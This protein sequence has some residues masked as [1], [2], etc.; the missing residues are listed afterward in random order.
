MK[1]H[2]LTMSVAV[3]SAALVWGCQE[4]G[5]TPFEPDGILAKADRGGGKGGGGGGGKETAKVELR[6][7]MTTTLLQTVVV[8]K[9]SDQELVLR[10]DGKIEFALA[11]DVG[12]CEVTKG[13]DEQFAL[14][15]KLT[16]AL[17]PRTFNMTVDKPSLKS[18]SDKHQINT[19]RTEEDKLFTLRLGT[20]DDFP[21]WE[22]TVTQT[23]G[24]FT[25]TEGGVL[26]WDR[27]GK[28]KDH[29]KIKCEN[30]S[31][32]IVTVN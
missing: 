22:S 3:L 24:T 16:N 13:R 5:S 11:I 6:E 10:G 19:T 20:L 14:V 2:A 9:D 25:F 7:G 17:Q 4:Q 30:K 8:E 28:V 27:S 29:V 12:S 21:Q 31:T 1:K 15:A 26:I 23:N 18:A 32:I